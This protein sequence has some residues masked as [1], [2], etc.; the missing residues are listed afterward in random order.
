MTPGDSIP[1]V[2]D[3]AVL[4]AATGDAVDG[5]RLLGA[6]VLFGR[7]LRAAGL[8]VDLG[9]AVDFARDALQTLVGG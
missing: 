1:V 3:P 6:S 8:Q 4:L 2:N 9:A 5:R 7:E